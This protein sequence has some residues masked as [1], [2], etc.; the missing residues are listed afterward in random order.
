MECEGR[1]L[2][3]TTMGQPYQKM[4]TGVFA[5]AADT[6]GNAC[7]L[8]L[9]NCISTSIGR[10]ACLAQAFLADRAAASDWLPA[11]TI[12]AVREPCSRRDVAGHL[13]VRCDHPGRLAFPTSLPLKGASQGAGASKAGGP[14]PG[15]GLG[16]AGAAAQQTPAPAA[17]GSAVAELKACGNEHFKRQHFHLATRAY[18]Q[19]LRALQAGADPV[20]ATS[21]A[22]ILHSNRAA[23][24][25]LRGSS[26]VPVL[27][28]FVRLCVCAF[29]RLCVLR[30]CAAATVLVEAEWV[31]SRGVF[32]Q[33]ILGGEVRQVLTCVLPCG[34]RALLAERRHCS[35]SRPGVQLGCGT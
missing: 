19:A 23:G 24:E 34:M 12:L 5:V 11:G 31:H 10:A 29:V 25:R 15:P 28:A 2:W 6:E 8:A 1:V 22:A 21:L 27:S 17:A 4:G 26:C 14:S 13:V 7:T 30:V 16:D 3:C 20:S 32:F 33:C 18:T 35:P 9:Y